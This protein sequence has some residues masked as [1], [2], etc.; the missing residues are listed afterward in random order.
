M[1]CG[2]EV[3]GMFLLPHCSCHSFASIPREQRCKK[4]GE[5]HYTLRMLQFFN[6][7]FFN[8]IVCLHQMWDL[9]YQRP[10]TKF[11][12]AIIVTRSHLFCQ[13]QPN[14]DWQ[15]HH[16]CSLPPS[17]SDLVD[18]IVS[19]FFVSACLYILLIVVLPGCEEWRDIL[20]WIDSIKMG[21]WSC[22]LQY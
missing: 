22:Q 9:W 19:G 6:H 16:H 21:S 3:Q 17:S 4:K 14:K 13:E 11:C 5:K 1:I 12:P 8:W 18:V 7:H 20:I 10:Q 2:I 15:A